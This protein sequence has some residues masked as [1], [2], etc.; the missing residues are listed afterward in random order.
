MVW[1]FLFVVIL[2]GSEP[3]GKIAIYPSEQECLVAGHVEGQKIVALKERGAW[4]CEAVDFDVL[5]PV[6]AKHVP[7]PDEAMVQ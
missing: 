2:S 6:P 4:S 5:D 7:G 1:Y 3:G